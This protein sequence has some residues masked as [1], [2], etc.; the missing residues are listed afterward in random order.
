MS[1][2]RSYRHQ[3]L[4]LAPT[5]HPDRWVHDS[6]PSISRAKFRAYIITPYIHFGHM[7]VL[8]MP[9]LMNV[10]VYHIIRH[11]MPWNKIMLSAAGCP[12]RYR[13]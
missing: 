10:S 5:M 3:G 1:V 2:G 12:A 6:Q 11:S 4:S 9:R 13:S 7:V 8:G